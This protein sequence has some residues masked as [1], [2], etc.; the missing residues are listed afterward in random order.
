MR[1]AAAG[2]LAAESKEA[3]LAGLLEATVALSVATG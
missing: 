2:A 1:R 3:S